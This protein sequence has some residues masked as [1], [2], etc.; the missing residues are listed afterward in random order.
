MSK[1]DKEKMLKLLAV[2]S[3]I[4]I[5]IFFMFGLGS[6]PVYLILACVVLLHYVVV[7]PSL[8]K[9]I[10]SLYEQPL[11]F[12]RWIPIANEI[13]LF[14]GGSYYA[15][16]IMSIFSV[17]VF[18]LRFLPNSVIG[19]LFGLRAGMFWGYNITAVLIVVLVI[20]NFVFG[21]GFC[22]LL[23]ELNVMVMDRYSAPAGK[24]ET[25]VCYVLLLIPFIRICP[26]MTMWTKAA[27][28]DRLE[29]ADTETAFIEK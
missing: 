22:R 27:N 3:L 13:E 23:H 18:L 29:Q 8:C 10:Y 21:F 12:V 2:A 14:S 17:L 24:L 16:L 26:L 11:G 9:H 25:L 1:K 7:A 6:L 20:T 19:S 28:M 5:T 15:A 4:T